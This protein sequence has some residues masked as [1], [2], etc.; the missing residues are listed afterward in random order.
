MTVFVHNHTRSLQIP[1]GLTG[2]LTQRVAHT[3]ASY[4]DPQQFATCAVDGSIRVWNLVFSHIHVILSHMNRC[5]GLRNGAHIH[6]RVDIT[7]AIV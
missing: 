2:N 5:N 1:L 6:M 7:T 3:A 4:A